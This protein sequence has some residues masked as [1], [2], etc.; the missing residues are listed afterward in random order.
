ME[1]PEQVQVEVV[2][3]LPQRHWSIPVTLAAGS[4]LQQ[5]IAC[6]GILEQCPEIDLVVNKVGI[7]GKLEGL[8]TVLRA[9]DR[10]EIYRNLKVDPRE[11][12][13]RRVANK[14]D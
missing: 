4:T 7:Y 10:V 8:D 11:A 13:R 3:A 6:S 2:Y 9:G 5:A 14:Q 1:N 12:R